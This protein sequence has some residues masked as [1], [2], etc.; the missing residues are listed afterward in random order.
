MAGIDP[1]TAG[2]NV[3]DTVI[4]KIWPDKSE[5]ERQIIAAQ[6][7]A[8]TGQL[9]VNKAEAGHRTIFV[10]GWRPFIGWVCGFALVYHYIARPLLPWLSALFGHPTPEIPPLDMGDL[11]TILLGMLGLGGLRTFE[12]TKGVSK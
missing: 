7:M 11:I 6:V 5:Q 4:N 10:A 8:V 1:L 3:V 9:E 2:L 12:K